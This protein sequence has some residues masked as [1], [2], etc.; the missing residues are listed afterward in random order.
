MKIK[1]IKLTNIGPYINENKFDFDLSDSVRRMILVGGKNGAGKTTLFKAIKTCLYGCVAYGFEAIN[2]KY[3]RQEDA[4]KKQQEVLK[5]YLEISE[6]NTADGSFKAISK[7]YLQ[8]KVESVS[9]LQ[10][11]I[12]NNILEQYDVETERL[13]SYTG[14]IVEANTLTESQERAFAEIKESFKKHNISLLYGVTSSGKTEIYIRL[15]QEQIK[16]GRQV[17]YLLPEIA[18]TTQIMHRLQS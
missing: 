11:L 16:M 8:G 1:Q 18:L 5:K 10:A 6:F 3:P 15:I 17:L 14:S 7:R 9:A 13:I 4:A 12:Q 2:A